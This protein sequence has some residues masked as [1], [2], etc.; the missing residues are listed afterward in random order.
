MKKEIFPESKLAHKYLDGLK[1]I[2]IG[3]SAHNPFGLNTKNVDITDSDEDI[4]KNEEVE[5][6]GEKLLVDH[7]AS[8][9]NLPFKSESQ[10][11]VVSSH[12]LEHFPDPI[13]ALK[14][15]Y[16][17]VKN[18][19][20]IFMIIPHKERMFDRNRERTTLDELAQRHKTEIYPKA[21]N[22]HY[23]VW[24]TE[25]II[26]LVK[27]LGWNIVDF[28]DVDDK[29]GNGFAIV[30]RKGRINEEERSAVNKKVAELAKARKN[31]IKNKTFSRIIM[32]L[33]NTKKEL[34]SNG[35]KGV[36]HRIKTL[37]KWEK[38]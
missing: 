21:V 14:E 32:L 20:Y 33:R 12:V 17:V 26:E 2:E 9:D 15:W 5:V 37:K 16:R 34:R 7:F 3:G 6:S 10:D 23:S 24:T 35:V 13:K 25:D 8:G 11:F 31:L 36:I 1:G 22:G 38:Q 4:F 27:Y 19:G 18:D 30:I 29:V 28:Q